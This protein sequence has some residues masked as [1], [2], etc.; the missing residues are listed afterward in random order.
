MTIIVPNR[1]AG[2]VRALVAERFAD[3]IGDLRGRE[4]DTETH[5]T[6]MWCRMTPDRFFQEAV[7]Q[8]AAGCVDAFL[9]TEKNKECMR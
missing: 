7:R 1:F 8:Y 3:T 9:L 2:A 6:V 5:Y 4:V